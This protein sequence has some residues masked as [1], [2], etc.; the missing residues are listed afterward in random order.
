MCVGRVEAKSKDIPR[1]CP[2]VVVGLDNN[3][4]F[5]TW[6]R[7]RQPANLLQRLVGKNRRRQRIVIVRPTDAQ[8]LRP[9]THADL[10][11]AINRAIGEDW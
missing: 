7:Q 10:A 8:I 3:P 4:V 2:V 1:R 5:H 9:D 11:L 6:Q